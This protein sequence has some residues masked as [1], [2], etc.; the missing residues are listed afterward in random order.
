MQSVAKHLCYRQFFYNEILFQL[1]AL[2]IIRANN[3]LQIMDQVTIELR[4]LMSLAQMRFKSN[5]ELRYQIIV[6]FEKIKKRLS[7]VYDTDSLV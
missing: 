6:F 2:Q 5:L 3:L 1:T 7:E 4:F